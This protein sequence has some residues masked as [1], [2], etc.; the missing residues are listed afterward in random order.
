MA[1]RFIQYE[2]YMGYVDYSVFTERGFFIT[3]SNSVHFDYT[4][5]GS[6]S[7]YI[8]SG[9]KGE[10]PDSYKEAEKEKALFLLFSKVKEQGGDGLINLKFDYRPASISQYSSETSRV[11]ASGMAIRRN[12]P[13]SNE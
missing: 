7:V 11:T 5:L 2:E 6:V 1:F 3:E 12:I 4:A 13:E 9:Y 10:D 8:Q